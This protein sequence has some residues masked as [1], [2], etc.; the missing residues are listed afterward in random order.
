M[1][2]QVVHPKV[3]PLAVSISD[4]ARMMRVSRPTIYALI[5][6]GQ[7]R[8]ANIGKAVRIPLADIRALLHLDAEVAS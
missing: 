6:S 3:E 4:A 2:D 1:R 5:E 7:L 8:R